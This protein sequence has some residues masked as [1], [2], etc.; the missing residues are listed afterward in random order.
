MCSGA[1]CEPSTGGPSLHPRPR[2][3]NTDNEPSL[4]Q[5]CSQFTTKHLQNVLSAGVPHIPVPA[6][7]YLQNPVSSPSLSSSKVPPIPLVLVFPLSGEGILCPWPIILSQFCSPLSGSDKFC[8]HMSGKQAGKF[9]LPLRDLGAP[10]GGRPHRC[11]AALPG[12]DAILRALFPGS[13]AP[14]CS[15][16]PVTL[17]LAAPPAPGLSLAVLPA[18]ERVVVFKLSYLRLATMPSSRTLSF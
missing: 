4:N 13:S 1:G 15:Q 6:D 2:R 9:C 8:A 12:A 14:E 18:P 16:D 7:C 10:G 3:K 11:T 17:G 5:A